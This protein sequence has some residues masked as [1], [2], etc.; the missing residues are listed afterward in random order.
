MLETLPFIVVRIEN[1][2]RG[3]YPRPTLKPLRMTIYEIA[4]ISDWSW[5]LKP[6][7]N[8]VGREGNVISVGRCH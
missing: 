7:I 8:T 1:R 5:T 6:L 3:F 4:P 2:D